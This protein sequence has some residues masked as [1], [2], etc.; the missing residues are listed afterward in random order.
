MII[1]KFILFLFCIISSVCYGFET[2][3]LVISEIC[4]QGAFG[5]G[6]DDEF[7][8]IYNPTSSPVDLASNNYRLYR[9]TAASYT[10]YLIC[11]FNTPSDFLAPLTNTI[12]PSHGYY[13]VANSNCSP[14]LK[15]IADA[16]W[17]T[18]EKLADNN[19]IFLTR[20]SP[21]ANPPQEE[22]IDFVGLGS[23]NEY[24]GSGPAVSPGSGYSI[25]RK[26]WS[27][28]TTMSMTNS[29]EDQFRGNAEDS[30]NNNLDFVIRRPE[31]QNSLSLKESPYNPPIE[32]LFL[33]I[34]NTA[35]FIIPEGA[36]NIPLFAFNLSSSSNFRTLTSLSI[37]NCG[38]A[39]Q[40]SFV[41]IKLFLDND[42]S[43][44]LSDKD[45]FAGFLNSDFNGKWTNNFLTIS[46]NLDTPGRTFIVVADMNSPLNKGE[47]IIFG[48]PKGGLKISSG[49]SNQSLFKVSQS[50][51]T[52]PSLYVVINEIAWRGTVADV[53]DEW[54]E[55]FNNTTLTQS[56]AG[57]SLKAKDGIPNIS[58][59]GFIKPSDFFLLERTDDTTVSDITADQIYAGAL[60][61]SGE[62][63]LLFNNQNRLV[64]YVDC[65]TGW[66]I[67]ILSRTS[68]ER[69]YST[70]ED[71]KTNWK[72]ND[73]L[74]RCGVD[75]GGNL[76][77]GT[78]KRQNFPPNTFIFSVITNLKDLTVFPGN[79]NVPVS[80]F[81]YI[82]Y[83][84]ENLKK[85]TVSNEGTLLITNRLK[86][87]KDNPPLGVFDSQDI[88]LGFLFSDGN[89][90]WTNFS[91]SV[92]SKSDCLIL[93]DIPSETNNIHN[94]TIKLLIPESKSFSVTGSSNFQSF[95][96]NPIIRIIIDRLFFYGIQ[97]PERKIEVKENAVS[98]AFSL[99]A[100]T[101]NIFL[102]SIE[103][104]NLG[105]IEDG[106]ISSLTLFQKIGSVITK[107]EINDYPVGRFIYSGNKKWS[108]VLFNTFEIPYMNSFTNFI[109]S[110]ISSGD[111]TVT[112]PKNLSLGIKPE[113]IKTS[114]LASSPSF[115]YTNQSRLKI[116]NSSPVPPKGLVCL[117]TNS[118][119]VLL[120]WTRYT[121][122]PDFLRFVISYGTNSFLTNYRFVSNISTTNY[123]L[124][125]LKANTMFYLRIRV[126]D[127]AKQSS[128]NNS[129]IIVKTRNDTNSPIFNYS[130]IRYSINKN[131]VHLSW[132]KAT[133]PE[134]SLPITYLIY[135]SS[136]LYFKTNTPDFTTIQTNFSFS[137]DNGTWNIMIRCQD[138]FTNISMVDFSNIISISIGDIVDNLEKVYFFPNP[139]HKGESLKFNY[140]TDTTE[141]FIYNVRGDLIYK[142]EERTLTLPDYVDAGVYFVVIKDKKTIKKKRLI[143]LK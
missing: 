63:L 58:L 65:S 46:S 80:S 137:I 20:V 77:N 124:T 15:S 142:T 118:S 2:N 106:R 107:R 138:A 55:L 85:I 139:L 116:T 96:N 70:I 43:L 141:F 12:I 62:F 91:L 89:S 71:S 21:P 54:M 31:P 69:K 45:T 30:D 104:T 13:L 133:D 86:L 37:T 125:G 135:I 82:H 17:K 33:S 6:V 67:S 41:R 32:K 112:V 130:S 117:K 22:T 73:G 16:L 4:L 132:S 64:D 5:G 76:I 42:L 78:P 123:L 98:L 111:F 48:I 49:L 39:V 127:E 14:A 99:K 115:F 100:S 88:F 19:K 110:F 3:H 74:W 81:R 53:N 109:I 68:M 25:E 119:E 114:G 51:F 40:N 9:S 44:T 143:Y 140:F 79:T 34:I 126:E 87:F 84:S 103:L 92:P 47:E 128:T 24:E 97:L 28:S 60:S 61:D 102:S 1:K 120:S 72:T 10:R 56:L 129:Y 26:A 57:W 29:G 95:T 101:N 66:H 131:V 27:G 11:R 50:S 113:K 83:Y 136:N 93:A 36:T 108:L 121:N 7:I 75:A 38:V 122:I 23:A 18:S 90:K 105:T 35:P 134:N 8:E 94:K 59:N 52:P